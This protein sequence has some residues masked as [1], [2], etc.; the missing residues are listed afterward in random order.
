[1]IFLRSIAQILHVLVQ[2]V[3]NTFLWTQFVPNI[4]KVGW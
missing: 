1:M 2:S 3:F 4:L